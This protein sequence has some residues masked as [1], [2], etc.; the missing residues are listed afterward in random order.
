V[1]D[2]EKIRFAEAM[3]KDTVNYPFVGDVIDHLRIGR[4]AFYRYFPQIVSV[5]SGIMPERRRQP[6]SFYVPLSK[7]TPVG[8]LGLTIHQFSMLPIEE[9]KAG[10]PGG[11]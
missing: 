4:T 11:F 1:L 3:L 9:V 8:A 10:R 7:R 6:V 5:N 2:K